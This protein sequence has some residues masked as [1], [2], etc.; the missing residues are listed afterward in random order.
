[1]I[2]F[3][4]MMGVASQAFASPISMPPIVGHGATRATPSDYPTTCFLEITD[5]DSDF[6]S[7]CSGTLIASNR[8]LTAGHCFGKYFSLYRSQVDIRCGG[9]YMGRVLKV[10]LPAN[11]DWVEGGSGQGQI[12][13]TNKDM[14]Q[15][16]LAFDTEISPLPTAASIDDFFVSQTV[17]QVVDSATLDL[18]LPLKAGVTCYVAGYGKNPRGGHGVLYTETLDP[19]SVHFQAGVIQITEPGGGALTTSVDHGDSGGSLVCQSEG[20]ASAL[21]GVTVGISMSTNGRTRLRNYFAPAWSH[22]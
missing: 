15:V 11:G 19:R 3:L 18:G 10:D 17:G 14:A 16:S 5:S 21:V 1:M 12:P 7:Q 8:I 13:R 6:V 22:F 2:Q 4:L 20:H 9:V